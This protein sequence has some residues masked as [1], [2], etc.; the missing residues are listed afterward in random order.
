MMLVFLSQETYILNLMDW[1]EMPFDIEKDDTTYRID[2]VFS[3]EVKIKNYT[4]R[5]TRHIEEQPT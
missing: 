5:C 2:N 1:D 3:E 4:W